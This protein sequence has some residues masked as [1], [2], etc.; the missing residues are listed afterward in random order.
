MPGGVQHEPG[1]SGGSELG[2][3]A[4][5]HLQICDVSVRLCEGSLAD[6]EASLIWSK[7]AI[8][9]HGE[10]RFG[11]ATNLPMFNTIEGKRTKHVNA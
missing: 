3:L 5:G 4:T 9:R 10:C 8:T 11:I 1:R 6:H 2:I 7:L